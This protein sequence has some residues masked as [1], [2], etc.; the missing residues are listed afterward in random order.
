MARMGIFNRNDSTPESVPRSVQLLNY[1]HTF[2]T[3]YMQI[4]PNYVQYLYPNESVSLRVTNLVKSIPL[5]TPQL[6]VIRVVQRFVAVPMRLLWYAWEDYIKG[7]NDSA[8]LYEEPYIVNCTKA[9][10]NMT[11]YAQN[12]YRPYGIRFVNYAGTQT[13]FVPREFTA[14]TGGYVPFS[15][16][17]QEFDKFGTVNSCYAQFG[18]HELGDYFGAPLYVPFGKVADSWKQAFN[19]SDQ[20]F[21]AFPFAAYQLAYSYFYRSPNIQTRVDDY[22]EMQNLFDETNEREFTKGVAEIKTVTNTS[23]YIHQPLTL[24]DVSKATG[25]SG[26]DRDKAV[27]ETPLDVWLT[28]WDKVEH[29]PLSSGPNSSMLAC[30]PDT[31]NGLPQYRPSQ[32]CLWRKRYANWQSDNFTCCNPWQ[33]RGDEVQIPVFGSIDLSSTGFNVTITPTGSVTSSFATSLLDHTH[34]YGSDD[35]QYSGN[36]NSVQVY[37]LDQDV[38]DLGY[39]MGFDDTPAQKTFLQTPHA[40]TDGSDF[41]NDTVNVQSTFVGNSTTAHGTLSGSALQSLYVSPSSLKFAMALQHVKELQAQIDNRY[42]SYI[43]KFFGARARDYRLDRPEFIGGMVQDLNVSQ[44]MQTSESSDDSPLGSQAGL[45]SSAK[46]SGSIRYHADE[47]TIILGLIHIIPDTEYIG[48]LDREFNTQDRFDWMLPN[49]S[50]VAEQPVKNSELALSPFGVD[51]LV[52]WNPIEKSASVSMNG[53]FGYEPV[54]NYLRWKKSLAT[55]AFRDTLNSR[56]N[57]EYYKPWL[58]TRD[59]GYTFDSSYSDGRFRVNSPT[60][61]DKFLSG[62]Y[63]VDNSNFVVTD[64]ESMYPFM[65]DSY[66]DVRMVRTIPSRGLPSKV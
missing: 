5:V 3:K 57:Y 51:N 8:F 55:G 66:F 1:R 48:G 50:H 33:Q 62:R 9:S 10:P 39:I 41:D 38:E 65:V 47:H 35:I 6:S 64:N 32:I 11:E 45:A 34:G 29:F 60:L 25:L 19:M 28:S 4:V 44:V 53:A 22:Y 14:M 23:P 42:Q 31:I 26:F 2:D 46:T 43:H 58:I 18:S 56:G 16:S 20:V 52:G 37:R 63:G 27:S 49:F 17:A 13:R 24:S 21:S 54:Y 40:I 36:G 7:E 15:S 61:T 30:R 59:F 12:L